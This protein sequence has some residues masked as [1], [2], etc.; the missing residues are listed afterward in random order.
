MKKFLIIPLLFLNTHTA[1]ADLWGGDLPLLAE[2]VFNT[3]ST[4]IELKRQSDLMSDEMNGIKDRIFRIQSI[5]DVVQ[6]SSWDKWKDPQEAIRRLRIIYHTLPKEYRTEK[7]DVIE[8]E[9]SKAMNLIAKVSKGAQSSFLSGKEMEH[10]GADASPGVA[11]KLTAS[12]VGTLISMEAQ[13]QVIQSHIVSL[14]AQTLADANEK[15][16][17]LTESRGTSFASV[18]EN[19]KSHDGLFSSHVMPLRMSE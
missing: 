3:L 10:R 5:A 1:K 19:L 17:R 4:M 11:Q 7:S 9:L 13:T 14:L 18:S 15:E 12:G 6:P 16:A 8:E 2:I